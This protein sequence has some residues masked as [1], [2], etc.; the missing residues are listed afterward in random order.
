LVGHLP[1]E[2]ARFKPPTNAWSILEII[3]HLAD[4]DA[5]DFRA[6]LK[7]TLDDPTRP[8]PLTDPEGWAV[9]RN[10]QDRD[11]AESLDRFERERA[12]SIRWLRSLDNPD[13]TKAYIHPR[14][15]PVYAGELMVSWPAHDALHIR[16]IAKRLF[17]LAAREG[18]PGKFGVGYAGA[19]GA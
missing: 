15:G 5:D 4:E 8:W 12:E 18:E 6:R 14:H 2:H 10:Y 11:L 16:Q 1:S 3:N 17:E 19:W 13:W 7:S 9:T